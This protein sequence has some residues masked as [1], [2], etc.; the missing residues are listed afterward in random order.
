MSAL[1]KLCVP[2]RGLGVKN[3]GASFASGR[4]MP[5]VG[6]K[7]SRTRASGSPGGQFRLGFGASVARWNFP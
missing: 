6:N 7:Y 3:R 4:E 2:E 5:A 1:I